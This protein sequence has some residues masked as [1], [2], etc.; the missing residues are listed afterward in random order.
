MR[1]RKR[2]FTGVIT[3][4]STDTVKGLKGQVAGQT[5]TAMA[6]TV[7]WTEAGGGLEAGEKDDPV[8]DPDLY[9]QL[10]G[11]D[12]WYVHAPD[13]EVEARANQLSA[14]EQLMQMSM[15]KDILCMDPKS[16]LG[17]V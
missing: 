5:A 4:A 1:R 15:E 12:G 11:V 7:E 14:V 6:A 2:V 13:P 3:A 8:S 16:E 10:K 9:G 17:T